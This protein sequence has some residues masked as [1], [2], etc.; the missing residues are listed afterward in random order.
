M[1]CCCCCCCSTTHIPHVCQ[2]DSYATLSWT[3][4]S[5]NIK[6]A[7]RRNEFEQELIRS[8]NHRWEQSVTGVNR[9]KRSIACS[10]IEVKSNN[11]MYHRKVR[12]ILCLS[13][14]F[15]ANIYFR[16]LRKITKSD[17]QHRHVRL[18]VRPHGTTWLQLEGF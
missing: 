2:H 3:R 4:S 15:K 1:S 13:I 14:K 7:S 16:G 9:R 10:S 5:R 18:S 12:K 11:K 8:S 17:Y 6:T